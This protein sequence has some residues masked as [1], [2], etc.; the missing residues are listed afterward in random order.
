MHDVAC[1]YLCQLFVDVTVG[2]LLFFVAV[3]GGRT[4]SKQETNTFTFWLYAMLNGF[5]THL[6][7]KSR[8]RGAGN[9]TEAPTANS[10]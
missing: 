8:I 1:K 9:S 3:N 7:L 10:L 6:R 5:V 2:Q 4:I